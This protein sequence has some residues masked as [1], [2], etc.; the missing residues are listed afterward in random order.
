MRM[1]G[2][3]AGFL[4][5]EYYYLGRYPKDFLYSSFPELERFLRVGARITGLVSLNTLDPQIQKNIISRAETSKNAPESAQYQI[6]QYLQ[7]L[8]QTKTAQTKATTKR[9]GKAPAKKRRQRVTSKVLEKARE[10]VKK[11]PSLTNKDICAILEVNENC[12]GFNADGSKKKLR[13][14]IDNVRESQIGAYFLTGKKQD[15]AADAFL[16]EHLTSRL[17][18][19]KE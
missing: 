15:E 3:P 18:N 17:S 9:E 12:A 11:T 7:T 19:D 5:T 4:R 6:L 8:E 2:E 13:V 14:V 16:Q 1:N 10:L